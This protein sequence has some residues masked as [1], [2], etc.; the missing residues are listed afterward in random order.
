VKAA[1][2]AGREAKLPD[3]GGLR[4]DIKNGSPSW[5]FRYTS[6]G[7]KKERYM[8]IGSAKAVTL[9]QARQLAAKARDL[10]AKGLDPIG[11]RDRKDDEEPGVIPTFEIAAERYMAKHE[12]G[13]KNPKHRQQ[14]R[15]SLATYA[16]PS[17]GHLLV[18]D[19]TAKQ[20]AD[21][22]EPIWLKKKETAARVRGRISGLPSI[23]MSASTG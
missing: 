11:E 10:V 17:L 19:I 18:R 7:T 2:S 23:T 5:T 16:F 21:T 1:L 14:W 20:V 8:G 22:L 12:A 15:N 3:G 4:L 9:A 6:P 13:W